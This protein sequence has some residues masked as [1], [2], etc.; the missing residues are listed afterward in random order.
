L[1]PISN[2]S[3]LIALAEIEQ[4]ELLKRLFVSVLIPPAVA[5]EVSPSLASLPSWIE[6]KQLVQPVPPS[7]IRR[8]LGPGEREA[9]AL[10]LEVRPSRV[11][12]DDLPARRIAVALELPVIGTLGVLVAAKEAGFIRSIRPHMDKLAGRRFF[13]SDDLYRDLLKAVGEW[14]EGQQ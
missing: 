2:S 10:A 13:I 12:L 1:L 14:T 7:L 3:P 4:L 8:A 11:I 9:L 6:I 5:A